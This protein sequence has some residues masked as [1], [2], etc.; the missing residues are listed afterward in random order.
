MT[1]HRT[2]LS[3][4]KLVFDARIAAAQW[5]YDG[6]ADAATMARIQR[7]AW[8][9]LD[10]AGNVTRIIFTRDSGHHSGGWWK[11]PDYE[12]CQHLSISFVDRWTGEP[13]DFDLARADKIA[14]AFWGDDR[15]MAWIEKP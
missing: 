5:L 2:R 9:Y 14:D 11:N 6:S 1:D 15:K 8:F 4:S 13:M 7:C 3:L 12:R 10:P